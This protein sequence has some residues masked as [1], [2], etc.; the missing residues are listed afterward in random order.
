MNNM[1]GDNCEIFLGTVCL[2]WPNNPTCAKPLC[3]H[4]PTRQLK[5]ICVLAFSTSTN[6]LLPRLILFQRGSLIESLGTNKAS[7]QHPSPRAFSP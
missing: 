5:A 1:L 6:E 2:F 3:Q 7:S 4:E